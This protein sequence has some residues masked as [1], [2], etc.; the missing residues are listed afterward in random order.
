MKIFI[1]IAMIV[2]I[3][4]LDESV[5]AASTSSVTVAATVLSKNQCKFSTSSAALG[6]GNL[7]PANPI[8]KTVNTSIN[9]RC[10]GSSPISTFLINDDDGLYETGPNANR[11]RHSTLGAE[12]IPY[13]FALTPRTGNVPKN[14]LQTLTISGTVSGLDYQNAAT[15]NY[16]D[17]VIITLEP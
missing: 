16:S 3:S 15:G 7:D 11:M 1:L 5:W 8:N 6:F 10:M 17:T 4:F 9:F 2:G 13:S 14:T 12:Y